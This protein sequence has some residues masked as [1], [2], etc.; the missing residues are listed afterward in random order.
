MNTVIVNAP[1]V[2]CPKCG[3]TSVCANTMYTG[4]KNF[5]GILIRYSV[6]CDWGDTVH[7]EDMADGTKYGW[8]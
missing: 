6:K 5:L 7:K 2:S 8:C 4:G 3:I 1:A